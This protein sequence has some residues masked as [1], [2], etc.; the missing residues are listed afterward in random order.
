MKMSDISS[1]SNGLFQKGDERGESNE[2]Q[3]SDMC[4][5]WGEHMEGKSEAQA[6]TSQEKYCT[7]EANSLIPS[8][9][10]VRAVCQFSVL[11]LSAPRVVV[12]VDQTYSSRSV[13]QR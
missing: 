5:C 8:V 3:V 6:R 11:L 12:L 4:M 13:T 1:E 10:R 2:R 7:V 9:V